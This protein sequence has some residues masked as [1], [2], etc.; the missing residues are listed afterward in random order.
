VKAF[1]ADELESE[2]WPDPTTFAAGMRVPKALGDFLIL[3]IIRE[4][5]GIAVEVTDEAIAAMMRVVA[6]SEGLLVCPEGAAAIEGAHQLAKQGFIDPHED[7]LVI[8]T[9]TGLKYAESLQ[10]DPPIH[11]TT[12]GSLPRLERQLAG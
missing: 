12:G 6:V 4:S 2:P 5:S 7:V 1:H 11:L 8:N 10:G 9:G 3:K